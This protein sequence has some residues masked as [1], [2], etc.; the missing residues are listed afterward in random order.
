MQTR[1]I[2]FIFLLTGVFLL[3]LACNP[4][5]NPGVKGKDPRSPL[6]EK[7]PKTGWPIVEKNKMLTVGPYLLNCG[8]FH[9]QPCLE[10]NG[11]AECEGIRGFNHKEGVWTRL[12]VDVYKRPDGIQD[13]GQFGYILKEILEEGRSQI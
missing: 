7:D 12:L 8:C 9:R 3:V 10:I 13:V 6:F 4:E 5:V 11:K 2:T 1:I